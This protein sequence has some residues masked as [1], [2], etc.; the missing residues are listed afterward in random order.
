LD[1]ERDDWQFY[2]GFLPELKFELDP[3]LKCG[4]TVLTDLLRI[5]NE[6]RGDRVMP[7]RRDLDPVSLPKYL[8][9]HIL[10]I[11]IERSPE[12]RFRWRL[13]GT[14]ITSVV[15]RDSTGRYWDELY[16]DA[17]MAAISTGPN[18]VLRHRRPVRSIGVAPVKDKD[19]I[20]S[21]NLDLPLSSNGTDIDTILVGSVY[22]L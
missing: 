5:W 22:E 1:R 13:I 3:D 9:P 7:S 10:L 17:T 14:Y 6:A 4:N 11:D 21:E 19:F 12:L 8:L 2:E 20:R 15:G 16:D 18:W